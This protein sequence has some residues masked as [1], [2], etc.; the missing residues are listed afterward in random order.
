[1]RNKRLILILLAI[2][3]IAGYFWSQSRIPDLN[4]KA[5]MGDEIN[6]DDPLSFDAIMIPEEGASIF[7]KT[8][9]STVNWAYTNRKG[10]VFGVMIGAAL[11][12]LFALLSKR[13]YESAILNSSLGVM[14]GAP[15]GVCV[16]CATPIAQGI[17]SAGAR[18]EMALATMMSSPTLNIIVLTMLFALFPPYMVAIKLGLTLG[19][20]LL[21]LPFMSRYFADEGSLTIE[22]ESC[23]ID[24]NP[25]EVDPDESW[26]SAAQWTG[27]MYFQNLWWVVRRTVPLMFVAGL[28]G[29]FAVHVLPWDMVSS[30]FED[31]GGRIYD[32]IGD[33]GV[34][35]VGLSIVASLGIVLPVP[36]T[37]DLLIVA[38]LMAAGLPVH[39]AMALLFTLGIFSIYSFTVIWNDMSRRAAVMLPVSL[40]LLGVV[41]GLVALEYDEMD[42][43]RQTAV[44]LSELGQDPVLESE[45][46]ADVARAYDELEAELA[47]ASLEMQPVAAP[48]TDGVKIHR[49][50]FA[51]RSD[52]E[53]Q[54]LFHRGEGAEYGIDE[55]YTF[56]MARMM[57]PYMFHSSVASGDIHGDGWTDLVLT[58]ASRGVSLYANRGG[59]FV[60]QSLDLPQLEGAFVTQVALV[61][62]DDDGWLDLVITTYERGNF[63]A[64]NSH[65]EF[66]AENVRELSMGDPVRSM[67]AGLS[68]GDLDEDGDLEIAVGNV[69]PFNSQPEAQN[70]VLFADGRDYESRPLEEISGSTLSILFSDLDDDG[71]LDLVV[72]NEGKPGAFYMGD[73]QGNMKPVRRSDGLVPH[74][75][76]RTMSVSTA[77]VDN[78]LRPEV[79][80]GQITGFATQ[81][82]HLRT[83]EMESLCGELSE[84]LRERCERDIVDYQIVRRSGRA[85]DARRC[86]SVKD[87]ANRDACY[88]FHAL[89]RATWR[90]DESS[91]DYLPERW[92]G[93]E[94][95]CRGHFTDQLVYSK[96]VLDEAI[97]S[98]TNDNVLLMHDPETG[99]YVDRAEEFGVILAGW[100]WNAKFADLDNDEWVDLFVANGLFFSK[101]RESNYLYLNRKGEGFVDATV[102]AGAEGYFPTSSYTYVDF[103]NDGDLDIVTVPVHGP[104]WVYENRSTNP[105]SLAIEL[106][107]HV[108]N[109][110]GLGSK[111]VIH[112]ADGRRQVRELQAGGG[113]TSFDAPIAHF[114]LGDHSAV[115]EVEIRWSTGEVDRMRGPFDVGSLYRFTRGGDGAATELALS[116]Q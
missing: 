6:L 56:D 68:F 94:M 92:S 45:A 64:Y 31:R 88:A 78:D 73:G 71:H 69:A 113:F 86:T 101:T 8:A 21:L 112:Y 54:T 105:N 2:A 51:A 102:E 103:D 14:L 43:E 114:G 111:V 5:D 52:A 95:R 115:D 37:F 23:P 87:P 33:F 28:I 38:I 110:F 11:M 53:P 47:E 12:G 60:A 3:V 67:A 116:M 13:S 4:V 96:D 9:Y 97:P 74:T 39:Y 81:S 10:M 19:F 80:F 90:H 98:I 70:V 55:A 104:I 24:L 42:R 85:R 49:A 22:P 29:S 7:V 41:G 109:R 76:M 27:R 46:V 34:A 32:L 66:L 93:V 89:S 65:G 25:I 77:D 72:G 106:R 35:V 100:T 59:R 57:R 36:M 26:W 20:L 61:D 108:G 58:S 1:M 91:C 44:L 84:G 62:L 99:G 16:N 75:T 18:L 107:D 17:Y 48:Q 83:R 30:L 15:L 82:D 50:A 40:G 63:A 79:Y